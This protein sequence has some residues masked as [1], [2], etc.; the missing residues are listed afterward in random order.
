[1]TILEPGFTPT[2]L[3][4]NSSFPPPHPAY[5]RPGNPATA[6]RAFVVGQFDAATAVRVSSL[7]RVVAR[8][9]DASRLENP[10]LRLPLGADALEHVHTQLGDMRK[11]L[12]E[13]ESWS[14]GLEETKV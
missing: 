12:K 10:P 8:M 4:A 5:A 6:A 13:Y 9:F 2:A 3:A 11:D 14:E 7:D 1:M